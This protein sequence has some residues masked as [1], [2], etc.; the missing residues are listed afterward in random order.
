MCRNE[1]KEPR[2]RVC[3][4]ANF[5][6][7]R[8]GG[9]EEEEK[10]EREIRPRTSRNNTQCTQARGRC[11]ERKKKKKKKQGKRKERT[12]Q[13]S[14]SR[15][16]WYRGYFCASV[17]RLCFSVSLSR[18]GPAALLASRSR[19]WFTVAF[20]KISA[21]GGGAPF[22]T[23]GDLVLRRPP[24]LARA[25]RRVLYCIL[26]G[27]GTHAGCRPAL[28]EPALSYGRRAAYDSIHIHPLVSMSEERGFLPYSP[29]P[30]LA[31]LAASAWLLV[32]ACA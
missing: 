29:P 9:R 30:L 3:R 14:P 2:Y 18:R 4:A 13:I 23:A 7:L 22:P 20:I 11:E 5:E 16:L 28:S 10:R 1:S 12:K 32:C 24:R 8:G 26:S 31:S 27:G 19:V 6:T 17:C 25:A 21:W 15:V